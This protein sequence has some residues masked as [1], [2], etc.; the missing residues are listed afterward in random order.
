VWRADRRGW[1]PRREPFSNSCLAGVR[2]ALRF[3]IGKVEGQFAGSG[4]WDLLDLCGGQ[5]YSQ[6]VDK[7][8]ELGAMRSR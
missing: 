3:R 4:L 8:P 7:T 2:F 1:I 5:E 6:A